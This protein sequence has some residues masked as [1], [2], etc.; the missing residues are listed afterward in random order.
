MTLRSLTAAVALVVAALT[1]VVALPARAAD[2]PSELGLDLVPWSKKLGER[3]Y[4]SPRDYEGTVK[5]FKDKF[6][7][8]KQIRWSREVSLP[9]VKYIHIDNTGDSSKWEGINIY[10]L[11]DGR[12]RYYLLERR[13]AAAPAAAAAP[14]KP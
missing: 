7:G 8:W 10:A 12:V 3:R 14:A 2:Q 4:E 13:P 5:Y 6:K 1:V 9:A 11:P